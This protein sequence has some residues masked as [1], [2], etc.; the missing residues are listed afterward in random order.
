[1]R[2]CAV[3]T[4]AR[5]LDSLPQ[6]ALRIGAQ[7]GTSRTEAARPTVSVKGRVP[8]TPAPQRKSRLTAAAIL[9]VATILALT[10]GA[11]LPTERYITP[12]RGIG[13]WLGII[14]GS[15]ML[16]LLLYSARKRVRWLNWTGTI[17]SW[18]RG[19]M[20]LG[21]LG[22][23]CILYHANFSLGATNSNVALFSM[24][25]VAG[26]GLVGRYIY[27]RIHQG[28]HGQEVTLGAL[29]SSD[30]AMH[31]VSVK[32]L[33]ELLSRLE[34]SEQR[35][36]SGGPS[37]PLLAL[38]KPAL[39][40][41]LATRVRWRLHQYIVTTLRDA[42]QHSAVVANQRARLHRTAC[43]YI[44]RRLIATRRVAT[45]RGYERLFSLWHALHV[46]LLF[47]LLVAGALHVVAVHVY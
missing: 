15:M 4:L 33:P 35:L 22:P 14:G 34:K 8:A 20:V 32:F 36:L 3:I 5:P 12:R 42:A 31:A 19:H 1:V 7:P 27:A 37:L 11:L 44:D 28:L 17:T 24:L 16:L 18:F 47:M 41:I 39:V 10:L 40:C 25:L 29:R 21:I 43:A 45:L 23:V 6:R 38:A 2:R 13:Y 30:D 26:S 9:G 46:P